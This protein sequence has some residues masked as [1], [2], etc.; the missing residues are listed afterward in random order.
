MNERAGR[1]GRTPRPMPR[2]MHDEFGGPSVM[3]SLFR[4]LL[5]LALVAR[6]PEACSS[7]GGE[8]VRLWA[9]PT[10]A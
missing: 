7:G 6:A 5:L 4:S 1:C 3:L 10:D 8:W 2:L 9:M